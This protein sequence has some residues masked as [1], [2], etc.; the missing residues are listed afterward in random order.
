MIFNANTRIGRSVGSVRRQGWRGVDALDVSPMTHT[1]RAIALER[2][3]EAQDESVRIQLELDAV[4]AALIV[5]EEAGDGPAMASW[6]AREADL[7]HRRAEV[8]DHVSAI[9]SV[10]WTPN[11]PLTSSGRVHLVIH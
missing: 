1:E 2:L 5:A 9:A 7:L 8:A 6:Y 3:S 11:E 10:L 4:S